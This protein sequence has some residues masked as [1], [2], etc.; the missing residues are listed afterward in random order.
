MRGVCTALSP[1]RTALSTLR[2]KVLVQQPAVRSSTFDVVP[3]AED[4]AE[5]LKRVNGTPLRSGPMVV[6]PAETAAP[7]RRRRRGGEVH[8]IAVG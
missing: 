5:A 3:V 2:R 6:Q 7:G 8:F 4:A 1:R